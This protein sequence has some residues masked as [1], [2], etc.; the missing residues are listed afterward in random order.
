MNL[1]RMFRGL[2]LAVAL[3]G[4]C[5]HEDPNEH[6]FDNRIY[7]DGESL[8]T[9][10]LLKKDVPSYVMPLTA[11]MAEPQPQVVEV[12]FAVDPSRVEHY[13]YAYGANAVVLPA[14]NYALS[15]TRSVIG[16]GSVSSVPVELSFVGLDRLPGDRLYVLPVSIVRASVPVLESRRSCYFLFKEGALIN[17]VGDLANNYLDVEWA[18]PDVVNDLQALTVEALVYAR[19]FNREIS[20]LLGVEGKF[21]LRFGD[22]TYDPAQ[23]QVVNGNAKFPGKESGKA[24]PVNEWVHIAVTYDATG[25]TCIYVNGA[26]QSEGTC[27]SGAVN[28]GVTVPPY[29]ETA[30]NRGFHIGYSYA[31]ERYFAGNIAEVRIWNRVLTADEIARPN[32]FY[33]V[34][35]EQ[36]EGLV[37]YWKFDEGEGNVVKDHTVNG[38]HARAASDMKWKQVELPQ[39]E[40]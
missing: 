17:V 11:S 7:L 14:E 29:M 38:N 2:F 8:T 19:D 1:N 34:D 33:W 12:E 40:K 22:A 24:I 20:T 4:G 5:A 3:V 32:H 23:L 37:A 26:L 15:E 10:L 6:H 35:P 30:N 36:S 39:S 27:G 31:E 13:N 16:I 21:L 9:T 25:S 18:N 28:W